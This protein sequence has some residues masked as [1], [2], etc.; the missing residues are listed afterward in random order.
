MRFA[1]VSLL[2]AT[3]ATLAGCN[4]TALPPDAAWMVTMTQEDPVPAMP[5]AIF[6]NMVSVGALSS[7]MITTRVMNGM[8]GAQV[9]CSV[10]GSGAGPYAVV[11]QASLGADILSID[12]PAISTSNVKTMPAVGAVSYESDRTINNYTSSNCDF[13]FIPGTTE[14]VVPTR[15]FVAFTCAEVTYGAGG[16]SCPLLESYAVFEECQTTA[17][18]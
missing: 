13:Y 17:S 3:L 4:S 1:F 8:M 2:A 11:A 14:S 9:E 10:V 12:I 16:S 5:C 6:D 15:I 7:D 18:N